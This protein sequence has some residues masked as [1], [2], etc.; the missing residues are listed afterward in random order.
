[1]QSTPSVEIER[2]K[3]SVPPLDRWCEP[4]GDR[5]LQNEVQIRL[6]VANDPWGVASAAG[7]VATLADMPALRPGP[8]ATAALDARR[9]LLDAD[10]HLREWA[11]QWSDAERATVND[12]AFVGIEQ[13]DA[14]VSALAAHID[15]SGQ[16]S[17]AWRS[18]LVDICHLRD[19]LDGM[20]VLSGWA[21]GDRAIAD[22][23][24]S[25]DHRVEPFMRLLCLDAPV[26]DE[27][28][29]R[30]WLGQPDAWWGWPAAPD[31]DAEEE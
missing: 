8:S 20:V 12:L 23:V 21:G 29:R 18:E 22:A 16:P 31:D 30:V 4:L 6:A 7:L 24:A 25:I 9:P 3:L 14:R 19:D 11:R 26:D 17:D 1:M 28:L 5:W 27:R 13:L 15:A 10:R 2:L